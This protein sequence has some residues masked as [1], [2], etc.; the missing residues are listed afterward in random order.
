VPQGPL[1]VFDGAVRN[2]QNTVHLG[3]RDGEHQFAYA[4][5]R[6]RIRGDSAGFRVDRTSRL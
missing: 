6:Q 4:L 2:Q 3:L 1:C 5:G